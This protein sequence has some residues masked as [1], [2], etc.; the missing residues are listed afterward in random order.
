MHFENKLEIN[1]LNLN[2][3]PTDRP[4]L[5]PIYRWPGSQGSGRVQYKLYYLYMIS[6]RVLITS[7]LRPN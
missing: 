3:S 1:W 7:M 5:A 2:L 4:L 6:S